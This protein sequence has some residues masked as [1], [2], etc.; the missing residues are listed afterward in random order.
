MSDQRKREWFELG[1]KSFA[2]V[3]PGMYDQPT[4]PCPICLVPF[5]IE[6][7]TDKRLTVEHV[8]PET[9]G[10]R[11]LVLT[12]KICNNSAGSKLD[13][14]AKT[15][16]DVRLAMAGALGRPHRIKAM[17][18]D[19]RI[20]GELLTSNGRFS[21]RIP[22]K[23]NKPGTREQLQDIALPGVELTVQHEP[24]ADLG[25]KISWLRSAYLVLF[26]VAGYEF[27]LDPSIQIVRKQILECDERK[28]ITF[29]S[30]APADIPLTERQILRVLAPNWHGGWAVQFGRYF[31]QFPAPG[32]MTFYDRMADS[33]VEPFVHQM[34]YQKMGWPNEPTLGLPRTTQSCLAR[35][36]FS[37]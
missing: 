23:I 37:G 1:A 9:F 30:D 26:A 31:V 14:D 16:E 28:M 10:G 25:A 6:A 22:A 34:T 20:N 17:F 15:K 24:Y 8:P 35:P 4:Y 5:T 29:M 12:C 19:R 33:G 36:L 11:E 13:A 7:L 2:R 3:R 21:L 32:D 27:V 18:G